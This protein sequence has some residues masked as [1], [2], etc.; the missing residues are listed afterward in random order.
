M[1]EET[2]I[3]IV[4]GG[5]A[6]VRTA[7]TLLEYKLPHTKITFIANKPHFEYTPALY[8]YVTGNSAMEVCIPF[9]EIFAK[10]HIQVI[11]DT[12]TRIDKGE[13]RVFGKSENVYNYDILVLALGSETTYFN[14]PGIQEYSYGMKTV[15]EAL[16]L[17]NHINE[18]LLLCREDVAGGTR[19]NH[20]MNF[21]VIGAGATGVE[22]AGRL[23]QY[24]RKSALEIGV[25]PA[26]IS[27]TLLEGAEKILPI[28]PASFTDPITRHLKKLGVEIMLGS[29]VLS[30]DVEE[31]FLKDAQM[32]ASTVIWTSGVRANALYGASGLP[33]D[34]RGK[35]EVDEH[36]LVK[37]EDAMYVA[38][39][40]AITQYSGWAQT[41]F[42]DG[43]FVADV[44]KARILQKKFP[45]YKA[46]PPVNAIPAGDGWA[47]V[48]TDIFGFKVRIYGRIGWWLRRVAD[49]R[50]FMLILPLN[51]AIRV[52][53][54][55][56][57]SEKCIVCKDDK[58]QA[59]NID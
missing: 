46:S 38:G 45:M 20:D 42:S 51:K 27:V 47:A 29:I 4:G 21:V 9:E 25:N 57:I 15:D 34:K 48:L 31:I 30:Q 40:G 28:L 32:M 23:I 55:G 53:F 50:S 18:T 3:V 13:K 36:L 49:L 58:F 24:T 39:D 37:G 10:K 43:K 5:F 35:V 54:G 7:L 22:M 33:V 52:F 8:R 41:A 59:H 56:C 44:I 17:R 6:G 2:H 11:Q 1:K 19:F 12:I 14:I 26:L 16:R